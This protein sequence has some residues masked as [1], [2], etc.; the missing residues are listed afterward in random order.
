MCVWR[1]VSVQRWDSKL[2]WRGVWP[3][4]LR[5]LPRHALST[6]NAVLLTPAGMARGVRERWRRWPTMVSVA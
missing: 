6:A 4:L 2:R 1:G 3:L 5:R